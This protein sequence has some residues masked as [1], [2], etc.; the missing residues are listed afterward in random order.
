[1]QASINNLHHRFQIYGRNARE[2]MR[3]CAMLLPDIERERVWEKKGFESIYVYA[4]KLAGMSRESVNDALR[5]LRATEGM[6]EIR[7][8]IEQRGINIIKPILTTLT[9]DNQ[10]FWA[11]KAMTMSQHTLEVYRK[12]RTAQDN[13][14]TG[15]RASSETS[16]F[17]YQ[18]A[19]AKTIIPMDLD[20]DIAAQLTKLKGTGDWTT[21]MQ[22]L[23]AAREA[24]LEQACPDS[25]TTDSRHIPTNIQKF[26]IQRSR[27]ICEFPACTR[28]YTI[29]H[30]TQR[31]AL[32]KTHDPSC[33]IALCTAH[34]RIVHQGLIE[35]EN[36]EPRYWIIRKHP[37]T[38]N[39]NYAIDQLVMK[40]R[41][42]G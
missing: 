26:I 40:Y 28:T 39:P 7:N 20:P 6:T 10:A 2:W 4:A 16:E 13:E 19:I 5:V 14:P 18:K 32:E 22:E 29:L 42:P 36:Q 15:R 38:Q 12:E 1:M 24:I 31:F 3:K 8:V 35:N 11:E 17:P 23:L 27:G 21:L 30:H 25:K 9:S 33:I 41:R 37:D 34:E